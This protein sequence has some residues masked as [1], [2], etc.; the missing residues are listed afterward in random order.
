M[1]NE[2]LKSVRVEEHIFEKDDMYFSL[3]LSFFKVSYSLLRVD[4]L[5]EYIIIASDVFT[6]KYNQWV[7]YCTLD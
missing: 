5:E 6:I 2:I 3:I 7:I 4:I 1:L